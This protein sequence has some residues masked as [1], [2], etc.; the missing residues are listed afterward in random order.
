MLVASRETCCG[1][2]IEGDDSRNRH[3]GVADAVYDWQRRNVLMPS[4]EA[5]PQ[6]LI[7]EF[8]LPKPRLS[9]DFVVPEIQDMHGP[10]IWSRCHGSSSRGLRRSRCA[11]S[12]MRMRGPWLNQLNANSS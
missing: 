5:L 2:L 3:L 4:Q 10:V 8:I 7:G 9:L 1:K 12:R 11:P 6:P